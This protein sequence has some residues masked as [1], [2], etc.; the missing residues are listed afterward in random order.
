LALIVQRSIDLLDWH[1]E[2]TDLIRPAQVERKQF[3]ATKAV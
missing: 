1:I 2:S 3:A